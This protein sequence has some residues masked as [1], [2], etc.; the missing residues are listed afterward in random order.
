M[1]NGA[2]NGN[3]TASNG[4]MTPAVPAVSV[5]TD[6]KIALTVTL[7][8]ANGDT[9]KALGAV[10]VMLTSSSTT[11]SFMDAA[12]TAITSVTVA[13]NKSTGTAYY[14]DS[15]AGTATITATSGDMT[16]S[17][18]VEIRS[19]IHT[20]SVDK[21]LVKQGATIMVAATGKAGGGTVTVLDAEGGK[22]GTTKA[23]DP[24]GDG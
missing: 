8:D 15:T 16:A 14:T 24:I 6:G 2:S 21:T 11:S 23:L 12:N 20:L 4:A 19:T 13:D 18:D 3:G 5:F 7:L 22:V 1:R 9:A 10:E 17:V